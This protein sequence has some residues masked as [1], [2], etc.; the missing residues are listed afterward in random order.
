MT[1]IDNFTALE[2]ANIEIGKHKNIFTYSQYDSVRHALFVVF[3]SVFF[4]FERLCNAKGPFTQI[5]QKKTFTVGKWIK[6]P[7]LT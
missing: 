5:F 7:N 3:I 2:M 1:I 4:Q 6:F